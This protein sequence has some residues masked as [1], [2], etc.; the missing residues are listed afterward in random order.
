MA[1]SWF[2]TWTKAFNILQ[3]AFLH[4]ANAANAAVEHLCLNGLG[5][6]PCRR[7]FWGRVCHLD[8]ASWAFAVDECLS[9]SFCSFQTL[10]QHVSICKSDIEGPNVS[11]CPNSPGQ[12]SGNLDC[13]HVSTPLINITNFSWSVRVVDATDYHKHAWEYELHM[14]HRNTTRENHHITRSLAVTSSSL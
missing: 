4:A 13:Q 2:S 11:A 14:T 3:L 7:L 6:A 9:C 8:M 1:A 5:S 12:A 10:K